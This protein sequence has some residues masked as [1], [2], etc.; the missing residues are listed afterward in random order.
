MAQ[1]KDSDTVK[2]HYTGKLEDGTVFDSSAEREPLKFEM[3]QGQVIKGFEEAVIGMNPGDSKTTIIPADKAFGPHSEDMV[4][5]VEREQFP[6][7]MELNVGQRLQVPQPGGQPVLVTIA[8]V[9]EKTVMLDG[10]HPL[11]GKELTFDIHLVEI[12]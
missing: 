1:V 3:G 11:A 8:E 10:N 12:V 9:S 7:D 5:E 4:I 2:V 6:E